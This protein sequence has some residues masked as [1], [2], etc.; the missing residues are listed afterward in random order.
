[1]WKS[2]NEKLL[3]NLIIELVINNW[4]DNQLMGIPFFKLISNYLL[5]YG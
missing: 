5:G 2:I 1:M 4:I 3:F